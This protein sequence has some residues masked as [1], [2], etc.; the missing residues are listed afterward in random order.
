M[1]DLPHSCIITGAAGGIGR[2]VSL[3]LAQAGIN[4]ILTDR[5]VEQL[6]Q[7][8][9][10]AAGLPGRMVALPGDMLDVDLAEKLCDHARDAFGGIHLL[11][12]CSGFLEDAR[13]EKMSVDVFRKLIDINLIAPMRLADAVTPTMRE[14][15]FGRII[16]LSSRAW[17]GNFGSAGYSSAKGGV[18]G[19]S[20]SRALA[21]AQYGI[22]VNCIAPGF[23]DTPMAR[24]LPPHIMERVL[25][26]IPVGRAGT[27]DD[28]ASLILFLASR[29]SGY[30]TGQTFVACGGR[31]ICR[32][33]AGA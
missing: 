30:I 23:I 22:T 26:S 4:L 12:N 19:F 32:P 27:V 24:S 33:I 6:R 8:E 28:I 7:L 31:S 9:Q 25:R 21:L 3:S 15:G 2:A 14:A 13:I 20:R 16:S 1:N 29:S 5:N 11:I 17:L 10:D 18:V